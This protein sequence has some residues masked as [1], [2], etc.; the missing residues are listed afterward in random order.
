MK[1]ELEVHT[2]SKWGAGTDANVFACIYGELG[3]TGDRP[4][5]ESETHRNKFE[6][7]KVNLVALSALLK[8]HII[9]TC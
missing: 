1:Y 9:I 5:V 3:D 7:G 8:L 4:L 6:R 2:G